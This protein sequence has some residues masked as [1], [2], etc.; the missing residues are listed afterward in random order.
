MNFG[1]TWR[2][3]GSNL[4]RFVQCVLSSPITH[5]R[6]SFPVS[7]GILTSNFLLFHTFGMLPVP[8]ARLLSTSVK[9]ISLR[10][11]NIRLIFLFPALISLIFVSLTLSSFLIILWILH[12]FPDSVITYCSRKKMHSTFVHRKILRTSQYLHSKTVLLLLFICLRYSYHRSASCSTQVRLLSLAKFL[13][14]R[15]ETQPIF[16]TL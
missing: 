10:W 16:L 15:R 2:L 5:S 14:N 9:T 8:I 3:V 4:S 13:L 1:S 11:T 7:S 6:S 12:N